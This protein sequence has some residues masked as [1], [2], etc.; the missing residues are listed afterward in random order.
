MGGGPTVQVAY[1][2]QVK[3]SEGGGEGTGDP[4]GRETL[5]FSQAMI[6]KTFHQIQRRLL[7]P[8]PESTERL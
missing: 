4:F 1:G 3:I 2:E 7:H 5:P 6:Y 8:E